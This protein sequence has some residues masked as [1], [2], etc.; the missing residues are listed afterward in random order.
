MRTRVG[1]CGAGT[2]SFE[3]TNLRAVVSNLLCE[4]DVK[5]W[6]TAVWIDA[7]K[8]RS[9]DLRENLALLLESCLYIEQDQI[10]VKIVEHEEVVFTLQVRCL[11]RSKY[12][13]ILNYLFKLF[14]SINWS[15]IKLNTIKY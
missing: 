13:L 12:F 9:T 6:K 3:T 2:R 8:N 7:D 5:D 15:T 11:H 1:N 4:A 10:F 14:Q